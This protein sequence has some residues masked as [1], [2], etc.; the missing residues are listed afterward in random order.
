VADQVILTDNRLPHEQTVGI[1]LACERTLTRFNVVPDMFRLM[2]GNVA[3][4]SVDGIPLLGVSRLPL[5]RYWNRL[6]K[7]LEDMVGALLG[8]LVTAPVMLVAAVLIRRESPG[9]FLYRQKRCGERG[10]EFTLYKLRTMRA[11]AEQETGPVWASENDPRRTR[12]GAWLRAHNL[13]ELPQ[14]WN[15][16]RGDMSLVGPRP[17]RPFFVEQFREDIQRYMARHMSKP[18]LTGWAQVNGLRG[19]TSIDERIKF[20]LFYLENWSLAFDFKILLK[21]FSARHNAY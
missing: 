8:L 3:V 11:D 7:R 21:T 4:Q 6:A 12:I 5:D 13:D 16:L 17:E 14:L 1:V 18:G 10:R 15:V 9:P 2:T 19:N 20:D